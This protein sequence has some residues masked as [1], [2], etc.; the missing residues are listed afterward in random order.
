MNTFRKKRNKEIVEYTGL[1]MSIALKL[2]YD[3]IERHDLTLYK[4]NGNLF[5]IEKG[6]VDKSKTVKKGTLSQCLWYIINLDRP[7][8]KKGNKHSV[9]KK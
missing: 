1:A 2:F 7:I 5:Y 8:A 9:R 4:G 6:R 3:A